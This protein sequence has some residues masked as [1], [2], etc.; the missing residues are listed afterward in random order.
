MRWKNAHK[1]RKRKLGRAPF[2][3]ADLAHFV[4]C[5][6][7]AASL[8]GHTLRVA[9][10]A[11]FRPFFYKLKDRLLSIY[12]RPC[13]YALQHWTSRGYD[14]YDDIGIR[15]AA[16]HY[17]IL[18][19]FKLA[20][21]VF[22]RPT[23]HF[24]Y[25]NTVTE[26]YKKSAGFERY[27][28]QCVERIE[29]KKEIKTGLPTAA[30]ALFSLFRLLRRYGQPT[31]AGTASA[32]RTRTITGNYE[33]ERIQEEMLREIQARAPLEVQCDWCL[34][35]TRLANSNSFDGHTFCTA[36]FYKVRK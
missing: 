2:A 25:V 21:R 36:C 22:H 6:R 7:F 35:R 11:F 3:H 28:A 1:R 30:Q 23:T 31:C 5:N 9:G 19:R 13:G 26:Y 4:A 17:H 16:H 12:A 18:E 34:K 8:E 10:S 32:P 20:G 14:A 24:Y 29:D 15:D 33:S 27:E